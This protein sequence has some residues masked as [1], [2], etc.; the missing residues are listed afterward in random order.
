MADSRYEKLHALVVDDFDSFR[1]TLIGMLQD[2]GVPNVDSAATSSEALRYCAAKNYDLI[3]CDQNLGK[4]KSGQQILEV[5]RSTPN[6]NSD[7]LFVLI[8]AESNKS[9]IMAAYDCEPDAYLAKPITAQTLEQRLNRLLMQRLAMEPIHKALK[10]SNVD[11]AITL[12]R[13][14]INGGSRH[15]NLCQKILG[16]LLLESGRVSEAEDLY[17]NILELRQMDWAMLGMAQVKKLQGDSLSAQQWLEDTIQSNPLCLKAY[18]ALADV[19]RERD[20]SLALQKL[21]QQAV[22]LSPLSILR[23]QALGDIALRNN[24]VLNSANAFRKAV[25]LGENSC[26]DNID[27]HI[28][29][30]HAAIQLA[31]IDKNTAKPILRDAVKTISEL[32]NRFGKTVDNRANSFLLETQLQVASG[33]D[34]RSIEAMSAAQKI[35]EAEW[36]ALSLDTKIELVKALRS[37]GNQTES[38]RIVTGLLT[39][40]AH[41]QEALQKIDCLL[42]EPLSDKNKALIA[43][44]NKDG[45]AFYEA[46]KYSKAVEC[47]NGALRELPQHIG[48]RLNLAQALLGQLKQH[49]GDADVS[50]KAQQTLNY[51]TQI[52]PNT[53]VQ[54]RRLRQLEELFRTFQLAKS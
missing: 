36:D 13:A 38:N 24:D 33:E 10:N 23:Q 40:Y 47:F 32:T 45:I 22:D 6:D 39:E 4:G 49:P 42:D 16:R 29:F 19:L 35:V 2:L 51:I 5:L 26:H 44:I 28:N 48:L 11:L 15:N 43:K 34:R 8:S 30:A 52:I 54:Y 9:I 31:Q 46:Q 21:I 14:E 53:H 41:D 17:R 18:D 12:C 50:L 20:D 37:V 27:T 1:S 7:S 25:K 3:L